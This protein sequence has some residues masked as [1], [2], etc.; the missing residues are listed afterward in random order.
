MGAA[1]T[2]FYENLKLKSNRKNRCFKAET[3]GPD[4]HGDLRQKLPEPLI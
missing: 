1:S 4:R 2:D 3:S